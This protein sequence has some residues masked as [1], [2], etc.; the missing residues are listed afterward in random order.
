[1]MAALRPTPDP[2]LSELS[3]LV[4]PQADRLLVAVLIAFAVH[5]G[6]GLY[7][8]RRAPDTSLPPPPVDVEL[9]FREPPP[10][11]PPPAPE[12][13]KEPDPPK[14]EAPK[15]VMAKAAA[16]PPAARAG[17][18]LTAAP[19]P[20]PAPA[21][22]EPFDFTSDPNSHVYGSGVVAVG[23]TAAHG[24]AGAQLGGTGVAPKRDALPGD[25]LTAAADLSQKPRL[26]VADPCR[27][28]FPADA[29]D[30]V[31]AASVRVVI[32]K[33]GKVRSAQLVNESP[34][35]QGFGAAARRCMLDQTFVPAIDR[36]GNGAATAI[37]VNV[38]F[39]R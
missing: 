28:F 15:P 36:D 18:V 37:N 19:D 13:P 4:A 35:G 14:L 27:G 12:P 33:D 10:P 21:A 38:R 16:P 39:S 32:G 30:D 34:A 20:T 9:A 23:G 2:V 26:R 29:R 3:K 5:A 1:M 31:A 11:E 17:A 6:L 8:A 25:G 7:A 22:A 24:L